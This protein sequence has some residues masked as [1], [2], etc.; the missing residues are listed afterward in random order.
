MVFPV[1]HFSHHFQ[2]VKLLLLAAGLPRV[3]MVDIVNVPKLLFYRHL[4]LLL[5][6]ILAWSTRMGVWSASLMIFVI[7]WTLYWFLDALLK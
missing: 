2:L 4:H 5:L 1:D 7:A 6:L 3:E